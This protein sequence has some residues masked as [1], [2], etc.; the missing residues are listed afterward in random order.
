MRRFLSSFLLAVA[1]VFTSVVVVHAADWCFDSD[2]LNLVFQNFQKPGKGSCKPVLGHV[3]SGNIITGTACLNSDGDTLRVGYFKHGGGIDS[4]A[5]E[6]VIPYPALTGGTASY[7]HLS[8]AGNV[9]DSGP[10]SAAICDP[11]KQPVP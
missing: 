10:A 9:A 5:G 4:E 6:L 2:G 8:A 3:A 7:L 1:A 11:P